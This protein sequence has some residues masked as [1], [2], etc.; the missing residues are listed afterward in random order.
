MPKI[1]LSGS[2]VSDYTKEATLATFN[3]LPI[4]AYVYPT[5]RAMQLVNNLRLHK[6]VQPYHKP[7]NVVVTTL[8]R[9]L[10]FRTRELYYLAKTRIFK[11]AEGEVIVN[12]LANS[13]YLKRLYVEVSYRVSNTLANANA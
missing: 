8:G 4:E 3:S 12:E 7:R 13:C 1:A 9:L 5:R 11:L 10:S 2:K 6:V